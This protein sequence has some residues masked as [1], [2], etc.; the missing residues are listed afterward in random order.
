MK[1][2]ESQGKNP[3]HIFSYFSGRRFGSDRFNLYGLSTEEAEVFTGSGILVYTVSQASA[4]EPLIT[5]PNGEQIKKVT[6]SVQKSNQATFLL[7]E[8]GH[9]EQLPRLVLS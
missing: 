3:A 8:A 9:R 2:H 5:S 6:H 7:E 1:K 4:Q